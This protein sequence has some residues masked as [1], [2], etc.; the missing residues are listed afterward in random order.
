MSFNAYKIGCVSP[1][2]ISDPNEGRVLITLRIPMEAR[3]NLHRSSIAVERYAMYRC[4]RALV[5]NVEYIHPRT[6]ECYGYCPIGYNMYYCPYDRYAFE[7]P[8]GC[9][10][11]A[12][13]FDERLHRVSAP[14]IHFFLDKMTAIHY[15]M[16]YMINGTLLIR[17]ENGIL[18]K[19]RD[20]DSQGEISKEYFYYPSGELESIQ[21]RYRGCMHGLSIWYHPN[22]KRKKEA[23]YEWS[24][25]K[26]STMEWDSSG[27]FQLETYGC[28]S[29]GA[30][31]RRLVYRNKVCIM[32]QSWSVA[33]QSFHPLDVAR[34]QKNAV[35]WEILGLCVTEP[36]V[37]CIRQLIS[38]RLT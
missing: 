19:K 2:G 20:F 7:Y 6:F 30:Q 10:V 12:F 38:N 34:S 4:D 33:T 5:T 17:K 22:G 8:I 25:V 27:Q 32:D 1:T 28:R 14:G 29:N 26:G 9:D 11:F 16:D 18:W 15:G 13:D 31:V 36:M 37:P 3:T 24:S 35:L 21:E 23:E